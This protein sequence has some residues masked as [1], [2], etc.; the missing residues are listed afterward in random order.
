[1]K[2][3]RPATDLILDGASALSGKGGAVPGAWGWVHGCT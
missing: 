2:K 3:D 1:M